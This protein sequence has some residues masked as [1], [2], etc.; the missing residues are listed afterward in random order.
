MKTPQEMAEEYSLKKTALKESYC[1]EAW[2]AGHAYALN[3]PAVKGLVEAVKN[4]VRYYED[5]IICEKHC[6]ESVGFH[7]PEC[8]IQKDF[9][10]A[11][12]AHEE[13]LK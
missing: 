8:S 2:L 5:S 10:I 13:S 7:E 12:A 6:D 3:S 11:L 4:A 1:S 9:E